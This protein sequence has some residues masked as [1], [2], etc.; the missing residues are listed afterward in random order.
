MAL[1]YITTSS[2]IFLKGLSYLVFKTV[3]SKPKLTRRQKMRHS[4]ERLKAPTG[5]TKRGIRK[6]KSVKVMYQLGCIFYT[7]PHRPNINIVLV[8]W[9]YFLLQTCSVLMLCRLLS[10]FLCNATRRKFLFSRIAVSG[11]G[12]SEI[13]PY[14]SPPPALYWRY[15]VCRTRA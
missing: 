10:R 7:N 1:V 4:L 11:Q 9:F 12:D 13:R 8:G 3:A 14:S 5:L 15:Q 2:A 6:L